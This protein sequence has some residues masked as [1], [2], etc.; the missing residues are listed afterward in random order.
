[1]DL[2]DTPFEAEWLKA[3]DWLGQT[4]AAY[5]DLR[6]I[7]LQD[8]DFMDFT[9]LNKG[10]A[11]K[12]TKWLGQHFN[13]IGLLSDDP[14]PKVLNLSPSSIERTGPLP[15]I[16]ALNP[17][18]AKLK[19]PPCG[20]Y[21]PLLE[22]ISLA[23]GP[24]SKLGI[25]YPS[26]LMLKSGSTEIQRVPMLRKV[27]SKTCESMAF[28]GRN[29]IYMSG[30]KPTVPPA[31][32]SLGLDPN[33]P[34]TG[35]DGS[36]YHWLFPGQKMIATFARAWPEKAGAFQVGLAAV[37]IED[38]QPLSIQVHEGEP[39]LATRMGLRIDEQIQSIAPT[40]PWNLTISVPTDGAP[41]LIQSLSVG[42]GF[43]ETWMIDSPNKAATRRAIGG[44]RRTVEYEQTQYP[45]PVTSITKREDGMI[46]FDAKSIRIHADSYGL[47]NAGF[48]GCS[49]IKVAKDGEPIG[50]GHR[51]YKDVATSPPGSYCH[52]GDEIILHPPADSDPS[53]EP[54]RWS[55][56]FDPI[57]SCNNGNWLFPG[58]TLRANPW[59]KDTAAMPA[60]IR[61]AEVR[62]QIIVHPDKERR[63]PDEGPDQPIMNM[64]IRVGEQVLLNESLSRGQLQGESVRF[65]IDPPVHSGK[66]RVVLTFSS[67]PESP[68]VVINSASVSERRI[69][70]TQA[71][72][73][74]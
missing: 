41:T 21:I 33:F 29:S 22:P 16:P 59:R 2:S 62:G 37:Q 19:H 42:Q 49:P 34:S 10:G 18:K 60:G 30:E 3:L 52:I 46:R 17:A 24:L 31:R 74:P 70:T 67:P 50:K 32:L 1:L 44:K 35:S 36:P 65:A 27:P 66:E 4:D 7:G 53:V 40:T 38:G 39:M 69:P 11:K 5:V 13:K 56:I 55:L 25:G 73:T 28:I 20:W 51:A 45:V 43:M 26:P 8:G 57:L 9:H 63:V 12:I 54:E 6:N 71:E 68:Y 58:D 15:E 23:T 14:L 47:R 61:S 48:W 72:V 64:E